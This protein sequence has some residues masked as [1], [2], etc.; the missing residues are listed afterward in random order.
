MPWNLDLIGQPE[1]VCAHIDEEQKKREAAKDTELSGV[2][3]LLKTL[4]QQNAL[5]IKADKEGD[6]SPGLRD[7]HLQANGNRAEGQLSINVF[8]CNATVV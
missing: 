1:S 5:P 7:V 2:S 3:G 8:P 6:P 4:V